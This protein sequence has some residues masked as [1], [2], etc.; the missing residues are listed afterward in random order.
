MNITIT[1]AANPELLLVLQAFANSLSGKPAQVAAPAPVNGAVKKE[2]AK[3]KN[4]APVVEEKAETVAANEP[5]GEDIT[6][7]M[8]RAAVVKQ[9]DAGKRNQIKALLGE[10]GVTSVAELQADQYADFYQK[11]NEL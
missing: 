7:E 8:I 1:I 11:I 9:K 3:V 10:F 4:L 5:A 6:N 2:T